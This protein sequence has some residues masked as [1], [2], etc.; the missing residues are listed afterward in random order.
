MCVSM[1]KSL[2]M[3]H[4][5]RRSNIFFDFCLNQYWHS[6]KA[7]G[8]TM[9]LW[10]PWFASLANI[11]STT[12]EAP[13]ETTLSTQQR[14]NTK[15][16]FTIW[17]GIAGRGLPIVLS[18]SQS[19]QGQSWQ[20]QSWISQ[21][22]IRMISSRTILSYSLNPDASWAFTLAISAR[23]DAGVQAVTLGRVF[24]SGSCWQ[25]ARAAKWL[26]KKRKVRWMT[27]RAH[28]YYR[29]MYCMQHT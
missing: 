27:Y 19:W 8:L 18:A 2:N 25:G 13:H 7:T 23:W 5:N 22:W 1:R 16:M 17:Q 21:S 14:E 10:L 29:H 24:L 20:G 4:T 26:S 3:K 28:T 12:E 11:E 15:P 6:T 9:Y